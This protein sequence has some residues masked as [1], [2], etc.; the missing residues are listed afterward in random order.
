MERSSGSRPR[1]TQG[2]LVGV[3]LEAD[4]SA[5]EITR[6]LSTATFFDLRQ[7]HGDLDVEERLRAAAEH[8]TAGR[9]TAA[10]LAAAFECLQQ[11]RLGHQTSRLAAGAPPDDVIALAELT[12][13][14]RRWIK[15]SLHLVHTCQESV[16]IAY[17]V[18]LIA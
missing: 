17:R 6:F 9:A 2:R 10:D 12:M 1:T 8:G 7:V 11:L 13:L 18:D 3:L 15:D 4:T 14:Q 5:G 16:R